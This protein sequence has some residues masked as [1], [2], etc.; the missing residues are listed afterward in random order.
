MMR[1]VK[2]KFIFFFFLMTFM[3]DFL[4][5][6]PFEGK[7]M[8]KAD[9]TDFDGGAL[10]DRQTPFSGLS[11]VTEGSRG[12]DGLQARLS[13]GS[14][15]QQPLCPALSSATLSSWFY[16]AMAIFPPVTLGGRE[17]GPWQLSTQSLQLCDQEGWQHST[18]LQ[19]E[20][21]NPRERH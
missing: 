8:S 11:A 10:G 14:Q 20:K 1:A 7:E 16:L 3:E 5:S 9:E 15:T 6:G 13:P 19:I 4:W 21:Q 18:L 2:C 17:E 12:R